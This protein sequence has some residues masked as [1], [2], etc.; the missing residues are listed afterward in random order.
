M[1]RLIDSVLECSIYLYETE[2][3]AHSGTRAGGS[4]FLYKVPF[5]KDDHFGDGT[6]YAVTN[7]HVASAAPVI[8]LNTKD[9]KFDVLVYDT[10]QWIR[11]PD[12]MTDL[13]S[14][15][16]GLIPRKY[17]V[18]ALG[19]HHLLTRERLPEYDVGIGDE[20][21][22]I[23][24]F[25]NQEGEQKNTPAVRYGAIAQMPSD[26]IVTEIGPQEAYLAEIRSIAG[27]SG[28]PVIALIP[29]ARDPNIIRMLAGNAPISDAEK[30]AKQTIATARSTNSPL[31]ASFMLLGIDCG[32]LHSR[33][34]VLDSAGNKTDMVVKSNTGMAIVIVAWKLAELLDSKEVRRMRDQRSRESSLRS[35]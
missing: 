9:D 17:Q 13:A 10:T 7:W 5:E 25:I 1:E 27:Y 24:R 20:V 34:P 11:H 12:Q 15:Q 30:F 2:A 35:E 21:F 3:D 32:H 26:P 4:G 31:P 19:P 8:R 18:K 23:G 29:G 6:L 28:S 14:A 16:I 33:E 22:A